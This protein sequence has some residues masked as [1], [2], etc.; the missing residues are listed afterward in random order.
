MAVGL[1]GVCVG[2]DF[3][4]AR[5]APTITVRGRVGV[6][7]V[8]ALR[9]EREGAPKTVLTGRLVDRDLRAPVGGLALRVKVLCDQR[10]IAQ[11][12]VVA[13]DTGR[14][15]LTVPMCE[16]EIKAEI[17]LDGSPPYRIEGPKSFY[18]SSHRNSVL[19][20]VDAP[21]EVS[22]DA[23]QIQV[24]LTALERT[25]LAGGGART[26]DEPASTLA[27]ELAEGRFDHAPVSGLEV[28]LRTESLLHQP[29]PAK[30]LARTETT[31]SGGRA[32][33]TLEPVKLGGPG[34]VRLVAFSRRT[35]LLE[36]AT[37]GFEISIYVQPELTL[38]IDRRAAEA[39]D[40]VVATGSVKARGEPLAGAT[41]HIQAA[42]RTQAVGKSGEKGRFRITVPLDG[43]PA[44]TL[45]V[46]ARFVPSVAWRKTALS[47]NVE[48]TVRPVAP[49]PEIFYLVPVLLT[50][51]LVAALVALRKKPWQRWIKAVRRRRAAKVKEGV[52]LGRP[53]I[54]G[55]FGRGSDRVSGVVQDSLTSKPVSGASIAFGSLDVNTGGELGP[56][57]EGDDAGRVEGAKGGLKILTDELG[58]FG[59]I[60]LAAGKHRLEITAPGYLPQRVEFS[61]PH[62]GQMEGIR[63]RIVSVR[64]R[65]VEMYLDKVGVYV[66]WRRWRGVWTPKEI[67][68]YLHRRW[69]EPINVADAITRLVEE[70]VY[71]PRVPEPAAVEELNR[72]LE[73]LPDEE[74]WEEKAR[75]ERTGGGSGGGGRGG[76][77][78]DVSGAFPV[79]DRSG[80]Q[81]VT[82]KPSER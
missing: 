29:E 49:L 30:S 21:T 73:E 65:V 36:Q 71:S 78:E 62:R 53:R 43:L 58:R 39:D 17:A 63:A 48:L 16:Q 12:R 56:D 14:W 64:Q 33:F 25:R 34:R 52:K 41:I 50:S 77:V 19:L 44:K 4:V 54:G 82:S 46:R 69:G 6:E 13:S 3:S 23:S 45:E 31:G 32:T 42:G 68:D 66:A 10:V 8:S 27:D 37:K 51:L 67:L 70:T 35:E 40:T 74:R 7:D 75:S 20:K 5:S 1:V 15:A 80:P 57:G 22:I 9:F 72:L 81:P 59:P 61:I 76:A 18:L 79:S 38:D 60:E 24:R 55:I 47:S 28:G 11:S 26:S 2:F